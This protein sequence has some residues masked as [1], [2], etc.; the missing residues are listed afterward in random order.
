MIKVAGTNEFLVQDGSGSLF[1]LDIRTR[2]MFNVM[3]FHSKEVV[4]VVTN[5]LNH[6]MVSLGNDGS[7]KLYDYTHNKIVSSALYSGCGTVLRMVPR[8][9]LKK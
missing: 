9:S 2:S 6:T 3:R 1:K 7:I 8:V 4:G 5:P